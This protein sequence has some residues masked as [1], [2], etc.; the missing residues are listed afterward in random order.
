MT[1]TSFRRTLGLELRRV[2]QTPRTFTNWAPL[3]G[4]LARSRVGAGPASLTFHTRSGQTISIPNAPGARVPVYEVFAEDCYDLAWFLGDLR[5]RPINVV[6]IGAHV[7]TFACW[8]GQVHPQATVDCYEP[9]TDTNEFLRRN[10]A[11][12]GL[13]DRVRV[14]P[15]AFAGETGTARFEREGAGSGHN[16]LAFEGGDDAG[17]EVP[18]ISFDD[19][20]ARAAGPI[21]FV[22]MDCEGG[23][24]DAVYASTP[25]NW[26]SVQRLVLEY[27]DVAGNSWEELREWFAG[28]GLHVVRHLGGPDVGVAFLSRTPIDDPP[29]GGPRTKLGTAVYDARRVVQTPGAFANWPELLVGIAKERV[30]RGGPGTLRFRTRTG[31]DI[32]MPNVPGARLP[33]YEQFADDTYRLEWFLGDLR[34]EPMHAIDVGAH[35]GTFALRLAQLQP[36]ATITCFEP[37]EGTAAFLEANIER[38]GFAGRIGVERAALTGESGWALFDDHG[39]ASVHSGLVPE[40]EAASHTSTKVRTLSFDELVAESPAPIRFVKLDCEGGEYEGA[41]N[42]SPASWATVERVVL[43]YH[44]VP[45]ASWAELRAWFAGVGLHLVAHESERPNLGTAWL[46]RRPS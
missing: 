46:A 36:S 3:L 8:L 33:A 1:E 34:R 14:H 12:N 30:A 43:E 11:A 41:F 40:G 18:T 26:T 7:G 27:H 24:Y 23:E 19:V 35:V 25:A 37:A 2:G 21:D 38:N 32:T 16:H 42:S 22:K 29:S 31:L 4:G 6:D 13:T 15:E 5:D 45:G 44:D 20:V 39:S 28:V 9:S 17:I 10:L